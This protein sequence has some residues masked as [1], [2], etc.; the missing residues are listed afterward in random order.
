MV[1][2]F[3]EEGRL[4]LLRKK[5]KEI[6][7]LIIGALIISSMFAAVTY[8]PLSKCDVVFVDVGQGDCLHIRYKDK[9][10]LV[11][12]GG[13]INYSVGK[14]TLKPYLLKN[15]VSKLDGVFVTHLHTDHYK[16]IVELCNE[17]MIDKLFVYEGNKYKKEEILEETKLETDQVFLL[18]KGKTVLLGDDLWI[19]VLWPERKS[20]KAYR[21]IVDN[22]EDENEY[23]LIFNVHI[24]GMTLMMT[25]D[26][27]SECQ[28][29]LAAMYG[30]KLDADI[31]KVAH[32]GSKYSYSE[33]FV[34]Y[35]SPAYA[36]FQV[37]RNNF[38]HPDEGVV[39]NYSK[40]D[41]MIYRNDSNGAVGFKIN[42]KGEISAYSMR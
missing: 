40:K 27:D 42:K 34:N 25:G 28:E 26:V 19:E 18:H 4:L 24:H 9:N 2:G 7:Y 12:G 3:S 11:D 8:N 36:V 15:G 6:T 1:F 16:G 38:G 22:E 30:D 35:V 23:S 20:D 37:G 21:E 39:E 10:Y 17:N 14:N 33:A 13:S 32:H 31:L 41:I 5:K 29:N